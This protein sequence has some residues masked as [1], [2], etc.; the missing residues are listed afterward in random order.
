MK[1]RNEQFSS[2][3]VNPFSAGTVYQS[4]EAGNN[5]SGVAEQFATQFFMD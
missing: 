1:N 2:I 4:I 3:R 5:S